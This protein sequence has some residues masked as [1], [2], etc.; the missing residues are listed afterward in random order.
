MTPECFPDTDISGKILQCLQKTPG[1]H[2]FGIAEETGVFPGLV[3]YH[4]RNMIRQGLV[5]SGGGQDGYYLM[6][7]KR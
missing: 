5:F 4:L 1:I 7:E 2:L 6:P 3:A